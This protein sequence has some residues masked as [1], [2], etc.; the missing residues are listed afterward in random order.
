MFDFERAIIAHWHT[1]PV[2]YCTREIKWMFCFFSHNATWNI[3]LEWVVREKEK[4]TRK[5]LRHQEK[6]NFTSL[7]RITFCFFFSSFFSLLFLVILLRL[8]LKSNIRDLLCSKHE[9]KRGCKRTNNCRERDKVTCTWFKCKLYQHLTYGSERPSDLMC[10]SWHEYSERSKYFQ[11][12]REVDLWENLTEGL[13]S[14][15][16]SSSKSRKEDFAHP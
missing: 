11:V 3:T 5:Q 8:I 10:I 6:K 15:L 2:F 1:C 14:T 7:H 12:T 13:H 16:E 4:K 9:K